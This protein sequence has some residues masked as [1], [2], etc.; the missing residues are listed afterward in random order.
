MPDQKEERYTQGLIKL[1]M[2]RQMKL[3][4]LD[5]EFKELQ[6]QIVLTYNSD[7]EKINEQKKQLLQEFDLS[8]LD[9]NHPEWRIHDPVNQLQIPERIRIGSLQ[10]QGIY[11]NLEIPAILSLF[12]SRKNLI[13]KAQTERVKTARTTLQSIVLRL[14]ALSPIGKLRL[15]CI[16]PIG[17]G[18]TVAGLIQ[19]LPD[20]ITQGR[21]W[22]EVSQIEEQL[23]ALEYQMATIKQKLLGKKYP[24]IEE[25]N[26]QAGDLDEPFRLLIISD[27]PE[28]FSDTAA[29]RLV[30]IAINGP[31]V[32][33]YVLMMLNVDKPLPYNFVFN[34]LE[35][36]ANVISLSNEHTRWEVNNFQKCELLLDEPPSNEL[37]IQL[38]ELISKG[39]TKLHRRSVPFE[40][41]DKK[42]WWRG[43]ILHEI[44]IPIGKS[45]SSKSQELVL[46][47][48]EYPDALIVGKQ[49]YGKSN[50]LQVIVDS[51]CITYSPKDLELYLI[52]FKQVT[53]E[54]YSRYK[55]PHAPIVA[56][57]ADREFALSVLR[58]IEREIKA[59]ADRFSRAGED[60][61]SGYCKTTGDRIPR[62]LLIV[63][64]CQ[65]LFHDDNIGRESDIIVERIVRLGR[66][67]GVHMILSS[68]TLRGSMMMSN[69]TKD[70]IPVRIALQCSDNDARSVM[71]DENNEATLLEYPGQ[72][73]YN[74]KNGF[75]EGNKRFQVFWLDKEKRRELLSSIGQFANQK[76]GCFS[77]QIIFDGRSHGSIFRN[78][79]IL[80]N[81]DNFPNNQ[82][83]KSHIAWL[84][85]PIEIKPHT[86]AE[87]SQ[88]ESKNLLILG[89]PDNHETVF[90]IITSCFISLLTQ[91]K[92][93][94]YV[95]VDFSGWEFG[96]E[97]LLRIKNIAPELV[98]LIDGQRETEQLFRNIES[99]LGLSPKNKRNDQERHPI[100][101]FLIGI[102]SIP[103]LRRSD[104]FNIDPKKRTSGDI[105]FDLCSNG[106]Q[107][108]LY[109]IV[110]CDLLRNLERAIGTD[111]LNVFDMRIAMQMSI[112][113]SRLLLEDESASS[114]GAY[115]AIYQDYNKNLIEK[116][117]PYSLADI[118]TLLS[119]I[120]NKR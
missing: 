106:T 67:F 13:L 68:Q 104:D 50:L 59:R 38:V 77:N 54:V 94:Q 27:F 9:W 108:G 83:K 90:A 84:G 81:L 52:D 58:K 95:F 42:E 107:E 91:I 89:G 72:A 60:H 31:S 44:R 7:L 85:E 24:T 76:E 98:T 61:L 100:F 37:F 21:A 99:K 6:H 35:N 92:E 75:L 64:E 111:V 39:V 18:D 10:Y 62:I 110:W 16:D 66:A 14:L 118:E 117:R 20:L 80:H 41:L 115:R 86:K 96:S 11:S 119:K 23:A 48:E 116:F 65:E 43:D 56:I 3:R 29:Q 45:N 1:D 71:S 87:F 55:L 49:G 105:L 69:V 22:T 82:K 102:Q 103:K 63:D 30:N 8:E 78:I 51:L 79:E 33:V 34:D 26:K 70:L 53:F 25:Y 73:I 36:T 93:A 19:D 114:L 40:F 74:T 46:N 112:E 5:G 109:S 97:L 15:I 12:G 17:L 88:G 113:D 4:A 32:G 57:N 101:L 120:E 2:A 28:R 47:E